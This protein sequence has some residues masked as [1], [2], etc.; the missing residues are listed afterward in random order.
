MSRSWRTLTLALFLL[1]WALA[2]PAE[3]PAV[4]GAPAT[5]GDEAPGAGLFGAGVVLGFKAGGGLGQLTSPLGASLVAELELGYTL[6]L[7]EPVGRD[8]QLFL[9]G[10]YIGPSVSETVSEPDPRLP[11]DGTWSYS[12]TLQQAIL[13]LGV[14]YRLPLGPEWL[15]PYLS[16]GA[17][18][19]LSRAVVS[20]DAEGE[21]FGENE[22]TATDL[23][24][25]GALGAELALGPGALLLELQFGYAPLD[26]KVFQNTNS[27]ALAFALGYRLFF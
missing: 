16:A 17:R 10:Q 22:E 20:G 27:G 14:L 9:A 3:E 1:G 2:A 23:G 8:L 12:V 4:T 24:G 11:G 6:P 5:S 21:P 15:R 18:L 26:G 25:Q 13:A 7:P 19:T